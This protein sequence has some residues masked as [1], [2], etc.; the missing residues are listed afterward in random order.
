[1]YFTDQNIMER[2]DTKE[3]NF[4]GPEMQEW[5]IPTDR[6]HRTDEKN[7]IFCLVIMFTPGLM[8]IKM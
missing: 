6:A 1:M 2:R 4:E 8:V 7:G 5:N 3:L